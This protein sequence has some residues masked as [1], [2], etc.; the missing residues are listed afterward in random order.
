ML[1]QGVVIW[2][3]RQDFRAIIWCDDSRDLGL[4]RGPTA[5]RNP[6][7]EVEVG[8][9]VAFRAEKRG[10]ERQCRDI[11]LIETQAAPSLTATML[12]KTH[13]LPVS[14]IPLLHLCSSRD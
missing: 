1:M 10:G 14:R 4:A 12:T 9:A 2:Y 3:S 7:I 13:P 8:D 5:W 6:M 11:H